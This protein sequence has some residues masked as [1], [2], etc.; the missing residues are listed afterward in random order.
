[1]NNYIYSFLEPVIAQS[2]VCKTRGCTEPITDTGYFY[3]NV[4]GTEGPFCS[5]ACAGVHMNKNAKSLTQM[6][7]REY[8]YKDPKKKTASGYSDTYR[9]ELRDQTYPLFHSCWFFADE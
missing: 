3:K 9:V 2:K 7:K 4:N 1:M 8:D 5:T 6:F